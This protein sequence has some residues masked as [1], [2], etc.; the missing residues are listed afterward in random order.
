MR[1]AIFMALIFQVATP[2][3]VFTEPFATNVANELTKQFHLTFPAG[4]Q[5]ESEELP[6]SG[7]EK[8]QSRVEKKLGKGKCPHLLSM[9][10]WQGVYLPA[11]VAI[12][13]V[14][15]PGS[16]TP[17]DV[18]ALPDLI[19]ELE[20]FGRAEGLPTDDRGLDS[21]AEKYMEDDDLVDQDEDIQTYAQLLRGAHEATRKKL[22]LWIV[23]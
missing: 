18:A 20:E 6:W 12:R 19:R 4:E 16:E 8:L 15:I 3:Q 21:L 14:K 10:A 11:T 7:W 5:W 17:L 9:E 1:L 13:K 23:K 22:P 2:K